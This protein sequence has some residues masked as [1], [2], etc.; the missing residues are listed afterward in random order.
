MEVK[1]HDPHEDE[2]KTVSCY[3]VKEKEFG[4]GFSR[5]YEY[6]DGGGGSAYPE[7]GYIPF[8]NLIAVVPS[9]DERE[10]HI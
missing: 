5:R 3:S 6:G 4:L 10:N 7:V 8:D 2:V 1:Y 9:E